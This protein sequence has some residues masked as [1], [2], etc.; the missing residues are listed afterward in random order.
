MQ[1]QAVNQSF[2]DAIQD[3][4][5]EGDVIWV[6]DYHL[7]MLPQMLKNVLPAARIGFFLH[8]PFPSS[9]VRLV[10]GVPSFAS[11]VRFRRIGKEGEF[12]SRIACFTDG[13]DQHTFN[14]HRAINIQHMSK[15]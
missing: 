14:L 8:L 12:L 3:V 2:A 10:K 9:E 5:K 11:R 13:S 7:T 6:H 4:Y 1:Q 15:E